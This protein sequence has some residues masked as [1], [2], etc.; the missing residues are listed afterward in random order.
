MDLAKRLIFSAPT[1]VVAIL[2]LVPG[3]DKVSLAH[4]MQIEY[5]V[6][7]SGMFLIMPVVFEPESRGGQIVHMASLSLM[8]ITPPTD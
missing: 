8:A 5:L 7:A 6:I 3:V 2:F 1:L 4:V